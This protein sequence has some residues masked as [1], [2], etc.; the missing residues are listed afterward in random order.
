MERMKDAWEGAVQDGTG[1]MAQETIS[2]LIVF[3]KIQLR[4]RG[5]TVCVCVGG[6]S[7]ISL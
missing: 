2:V 4:K 6:V 1:R 7:F 3:T 5:E